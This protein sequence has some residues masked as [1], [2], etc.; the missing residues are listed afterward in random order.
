MTGSVL[1]AC[2]GG[3]SRVRRALFPGEYRGYE[4][5]VRLMGAKM[6]YTTPQIERIRKL[7]PFF[8][9]GTASKNNSFMYISSKPH[10]YNVNLY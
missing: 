6:V 3:S 5:P 9:Q 8:L 4:I 7:D 2:D 1:V 10:V